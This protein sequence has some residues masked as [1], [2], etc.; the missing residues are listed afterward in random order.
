MGVISRVF[1]LA[2]PLSAERLHQLSTTPNRHNVVHE[3]NHLIRCRL[4]LLS[5]CCKRRDQK[6]HAGDLSFF[7]PDF[8]SSGVWRLAKFSGRLGWKRR[9]PIP[10][11][12][13]I[14]HSYHWA[15]LGHGL[16]WTLRGRCYPACQPSS[17][18]FL[19]PWVREHGPSPL[20]STAQSHTKELSC[21]V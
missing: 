2:F 10:R 14:R 4:G 18:C 9:Q 17:S 15:C 3:T 19:L 5:C 7:V 6:A 1:A 13:R 12:T 8:G 21:S 11:F 16:E 20:V